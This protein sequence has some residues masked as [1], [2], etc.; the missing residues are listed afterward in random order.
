[1]H[2]KGKDKYHN[3]RVG[4]NSRLDTI[5]AAVLLEKFE[6]FPKELKSCNE[7]AEFYTKTFSHRFKTPMVPDG[8]YSSWHNTQLLLIIVTPKLQGDK[9]APTMIY[10]RTCMHQQSALSILHKEGDFPVAEELAR[11]AFSLPMHGY[12]GKT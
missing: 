2:G 11:T 8:Y 12:L 6:V 10:Y 7:V 9:G 3:V 1:M 4:M 5:Q